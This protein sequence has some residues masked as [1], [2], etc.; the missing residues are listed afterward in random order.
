VLKR[1]SLFLHICALLVLLC[2]PSIFNIL[3]LAGEVVMHELGALVK[4]VVF[5]KVSF[6]LAMRELRDLVQ[7]WDSG[8]CFLVNKSKLMS[9][10]QMED[11]II[12][13][14]LLIGP[15]PPQPLGSGI[16]MMHV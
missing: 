15:V 11:E 7:G 3:I 9:F 16:S 2:I 6:Q 4:V 14:L 12:H 10:Y 5:E 13:S 1:D 8:S